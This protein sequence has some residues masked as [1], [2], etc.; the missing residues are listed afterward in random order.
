MNLVDSSGWLEYFANSKNADFFAA[1]IENTEHLI[2]STINLYEV[3]KKIFQQRDENSALQAIALM[4]QGKVVDV[5][6]SISL[7]SAKQSIDLKLPMADSIIL[8]TAHVFSATLWTQDSDFKDIPGIK[9]IQ[10]SS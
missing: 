3:F 1:A 4:Q 10:K 2:V 6:S 9:Y 8:T 7:L 5:D